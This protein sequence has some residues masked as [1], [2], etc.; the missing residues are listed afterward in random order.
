[1][2]PSGTPRSLGILRAGSQDSPSPL[3]WITRLNPRGRSPRR[4]ARGG[5][6]GADIFRNFLFKARWS[7]PST[8]SISVRTNRILLGKRRVASA[9]NHQ[10]VCQ[11]GAR[12]LLR[13][14]S[15]N[16][17]FGGP[18]TSL[19]LLQ[20]RAAFE[21]LQIHQNITARAEQT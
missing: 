14:F 5:S 4:A 16:H 19:V 1:M 21:H 20:S 6:T 3:C 18:A 10:N 8:K 11:T 9:Q 15:K 7:L 12:K 17:V 13:F 2:E